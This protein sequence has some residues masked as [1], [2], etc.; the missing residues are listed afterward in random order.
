MKKRVRAHSLKEALVRGVEEFVDIAE[1]AKSVE[2]TVKIS[3]DSPPTC[4]YK[5][6]EFPL[7]IETKST[8]E[9]E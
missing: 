3:K 8:R 9:E 4:S 7:A 5:V 1:I 6:D 2:F